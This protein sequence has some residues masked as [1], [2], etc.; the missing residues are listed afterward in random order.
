MIRVV[1][2]TN[3][4]LNI[5]DFFCLKSERNMKL[6]YESYYLSFRLFHN[7]IYLDQLLSI[8]N[9]LYFFCRCCWND[10]PQRCRTHRQKKKQKQPC[11]FPVSL[12]TMALGHFQQRFVSRKKLKYHGECIFLLLFYFILKRAPRTDAS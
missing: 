7:N 10:K 5:G 9:F 12:I 8:F 1:Y 6:R 11:L 3:T 4:S 2:S